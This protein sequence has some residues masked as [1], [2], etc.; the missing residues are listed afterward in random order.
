MVDRP[1]PSN[2]ESCSTTV[3]G[4]PALAKFMVMPPPM[5]PAPITPALSNCFRSRFL[6]TPGIFAAARSA[7]KTW[8]IAFDSSDTTQTSN[9]SRSRANPSSN[10]NST[11]ASTHSIQAYGARIPRARRSIC[12]RL[13]S[14]NSE[15]STSTVRS[16]ANRCG[17]LVCPTSRANAN[18]PSTSSVSMS[19]SQIPSATAS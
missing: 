3:T 18:A 1:L 16:R 17:L 15:S 10:G 11:A 6:S 2:S 19:W 12:F 13:T 9:I 14:N 7:K 5:V 4:M 8:R